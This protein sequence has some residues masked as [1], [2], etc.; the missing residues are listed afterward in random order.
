MRPRTAIML[1]AITV[2]RADVRWRWTLNV[3]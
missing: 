2:R 1:A 3:L